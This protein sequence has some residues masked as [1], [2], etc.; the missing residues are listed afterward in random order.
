M[1]KRGRV[2]G[3]CENTGSQRGKKLKEKKIN[4]TKRGDENR[5]KRKANASKEEIFKK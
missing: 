1:Q 3:G 4:D 5:Y 2:V